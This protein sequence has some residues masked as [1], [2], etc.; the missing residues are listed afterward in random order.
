MNIFITGEFKLV[1]PYIIVIV[2][3]FIVWSYDTRVVIPKS[4]ESPKVRSQG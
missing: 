4:S 1:M 2:I 3:D